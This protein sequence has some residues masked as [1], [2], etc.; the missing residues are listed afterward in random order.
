MGQPSATCAEATR[1]RFCPEGRLNH[2]GRL[3]R[4]CIGAVCLALHSGVP[5]V[6]VGFYVT[7]R[8]AHVLRASVDGRATYGRWQF[9]GA[10]QVEIGRAWWPRHCEPGSMAPG[11]RKYGLERRLTDELMQQIETLVGQAKA[12][13]RPNPVHDE[14][15]S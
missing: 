2:G 6:P 15:E 1:S 3:H 10:C 4:G 13:A 14:Y 7:D 5:I 8:Y 12:R 9:G 11:E